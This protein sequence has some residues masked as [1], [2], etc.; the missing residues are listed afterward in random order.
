MIA[1]NILLLR[2]VLHKTVLQR[3]L[4]IVKMRRGAYNQGTMQLTIDTHGINVA[5][6]P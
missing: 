3:M 6:L 5:A 1:D 2:Y 4:S